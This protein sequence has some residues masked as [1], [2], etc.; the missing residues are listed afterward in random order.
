[1][2]SFVQK[3][4]FAG[5]LIAAIFVSYASAEET[6]GEVLYKKHCIGCHPS[7]IKFSHGSD[8]LEIVR[9]PPAG[10]PVFDENKLFQSNAAAIADY[11]KAQ[12]A[13]KPR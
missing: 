10:M 11:I 6:K 7:T 5:P 3:A 1:M 4:L 8:V 2:R 9:N 12:N 13:Q